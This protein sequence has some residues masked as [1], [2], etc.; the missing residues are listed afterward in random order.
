M[1]TAQTGGGAATH[2]GTEYQNRVAAWVAV[3]ILAEQA[4]TPL[5]DFAAPTTLDFLRCE[6][7]EPVDD[8][9]IGASNSGHV[10]LQAKHSI[11]FGTTPDS[12]LAGVIDQFVRQFHAHPVVNR[13]PS[14]DRPLDKNV[15]RLV[16]AT[17]SGSSARVR[18]GLPT[19]LN[20]IRTLAPNQPIDASAVSQDEQEVLG[21]LKDHVTRSWKSSASSRR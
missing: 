1:C 12:E 3:R 11:S 17:S 16:L 19:I 18:V 15:D 13:Q 8:S 7:L 21:I 9:L 10:F 5:W 6:T 14:W 20:R 2:S 4:A